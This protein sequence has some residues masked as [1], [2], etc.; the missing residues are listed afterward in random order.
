MT[1]PPTP[2]RNAAAIVL[3]LC[4]GAESSAANLTITGNL[5]ASLAR[6]AGRSAS[7]TRLEGDMLD[8]S[9][10]RINGSEELGGGATAI[11]KIAVPVDVS[12][13]STGGNFDD[14][15][16]GV[17]S[18]WGRATVGRQFPAGID[19]ISGSL[20]VYEVSGSNVHVLPLAL[21]ATNAFTGYSARTNNSVK[22]RWENNGLTIGASAAT[23][24]VA[25]VTDSAGVAFDTGPCQYAATW[26]QYRGGAVAPGGR[27]RLAGAGVNCAMP[28]GRVFAS[29]YQR[30]LRA[31]ADG[32]VRRNLIVHLGARRRVSERVTLTG[33]LYLDHR[34]SPGGEPG[35]DGDKATVVLSAAYAL[36]QTTRITALAFANLMRDG[37][38]Y[39][40]VNVSALGTEP[41][42]AGV[43]GAALTLSVYF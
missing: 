24:E 31:A 15:F 27:Q 1:S 4:A 20:D 28:H 17:E 16:V 26:L 2:W 41:G 10:I 14:V 21:L 19:R 39:D 36:S 13:G 3:A 34:T 6:Y 8:A 11:L 29:A 30:D 40:D 35:E 37:Y 33:G 25:G 18:T 9:A 32:P 5:G 38:R 12:S 7:A 23:A 43:R 42:A 22:Y